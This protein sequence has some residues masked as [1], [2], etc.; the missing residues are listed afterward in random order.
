MV[1]S[2]C[3]DN[4]LEN[5]YMDFK[6]LVTEGWI[7]LLWAFVGDYEMTIQRIGIEEQGTPRIPNDTFIMADIY[8][9][10]TWS[11]RRSVSSTI[12]DYIYRLSQ[13]QM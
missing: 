5:R 1:E 9:S 8:Q 7:T 4:F 11:I 6:G 10:S 2:G 12:V 13:C 3:S